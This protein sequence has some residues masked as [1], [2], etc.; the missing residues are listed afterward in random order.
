MI[1]CECATIASV[2]KC[3][4]CQ[5]MHPTSKISIAELSQVKLG[6]KSHSQNWMA[7]VY[8]KQGKEGQKNS[9]QNLL[10]KLLT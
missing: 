8:R 10:A 6:K 5:S 4:P 1:F 9:N 3:Q 2:G 7:M